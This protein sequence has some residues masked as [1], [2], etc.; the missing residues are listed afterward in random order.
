MGKF[1]SWV[2]RHLSQEGLVASLRR[3]ALKQSYVGSRERHVALV[4]PPIPR[5]LGVIAIY[6]SVAIAMVQT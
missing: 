4:V 1:L 3:G 6:K 5:E 2:V